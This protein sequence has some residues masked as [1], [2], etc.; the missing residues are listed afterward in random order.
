MYDVY[1]FGVTCDYTVDSS[2][3]G[4]FQS[5]PQPDNSDSYLS[6]FF[7]FGRF[8]KWKESN[9][10][11]FTEYGYVNQNWQTVDETQGRYENGDDDAYNNVNDDAGQQQ[12]EDDG[13]VV[14]DEQDSGYDPYQAFDIGK[15]DT[16]SHLWTYDL[17]VS[18]AD[19]NEY[20]EC[21][22][23]IELMRKDLL[24][25]SDLSQCPEECGVCS[26]C[27]HSVCDNFLPSQLVASGADMKNGTSA[28]VTAA[29]LGT[30]LLATCVA[31]KRRS[32]SGWDEDKQERLVDTESSYSSQNWSVVLDNQGLPAEDQTK[33][34]N[35]KDK[36]ESKPVW[37]APDVSTIPS[38]PLFPDLLKGSIKPR[39]PGPSK[40]SKSVEMAPVEAPTTADAKKKSGN[41]G[42]APLIVTSSNASVPSS[43]S[44]G[45]SSSG[46]HQ[47]VS[48][49][50]SS[51]DSNP[52]DDNEQEH[53]NH[54][55]RSDGKSIGTLEGE[56]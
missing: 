40:K 53:N 52:D 13:V 7:T 8:S 44:D 24:S 4:Y 25:C 16:Y 45:D 5:D 14:V 17:F 39:T 23:A 43:I 9:D 38:K 29:V 50:S 48:S 35:K 47:S 27:L 56:I 34:K 31:L 3:Y 32:G 15:C 1:N 26:N 19:G 11:Y 21:T 6:S 18:C 12:Q 20:C 10:D 22:Y 37:L 41:T 46:S 28:I 30:A 33:G 55:T 42:L 2:S 51:S 54:E 36:P 49:H